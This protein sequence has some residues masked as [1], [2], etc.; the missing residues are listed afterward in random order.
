MGPSPKPRSRVDAAHPRALR[1]SR[2]TFSGGERMMTHQDEGSSTVEIAMFTPAFLL[3]LLLLVGMGR[4]AST[5]ADVD[6]AARDAA[7]AASIRRDL[8]S[9]Q[10]AAQDAARATLSDRGILCENLA[11]Q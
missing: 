5:R 10:Q 7:R 1:R 2:R 9:A 8:G 11:V 3:F 4:L 6:G